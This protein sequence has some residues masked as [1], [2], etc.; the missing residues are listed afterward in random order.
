MT[1]NMV[2]PM[3]EGNYIAFFRFVHGDNQRF[4]QKVWCDIMVQPSAPKAEE[5]KEERS[6][7]L[8]DSVEEPMEAEIKFDLVE[9]PKD[10]Q[11]VDLSQSHFEEKPSAEDLERIAYM[12]KVEGINDQKLAEN[13]RCCL[14]MGYANFEVNLNM[15]QRN[16]NDLVLAMNKLCN[17]MVTESMFQ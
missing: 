12:Q 14:D 11:P 13:L 7:L 10:E 8:N 17:G 1:V 2:A 5:P 4:G 6:S 15:L 3:R 16:N 9:H